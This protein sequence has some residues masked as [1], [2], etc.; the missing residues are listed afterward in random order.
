METLDQLLYWRG[1]ASDYFNYRG[2]KI[3][4][5]L[6]NRKALLRAMG[7]DPDDKAAVANAAYAL[8][9]APWTEWV[10]PFQVIEKHNQC[11]FFVNVSPAELEQEFSFEVVLEDG[12]I[13]RGKFTPSKQPEVGDYA[14]DGVRYSRRVV[15]C[16]ALPLG[17]H[18]LSVLLGDQI[19]DGQLAVVPE[20]AYLPSKLAHGE[21]I[22][23]IIVQLYTLRTQRNWGIGDLS[24][25]K[26][27][28]EK[29]SASGA[30]IIGLNPLHVLCTPV[31]HHYSPYSP[32]D[33]RYIEPLYIDPEAIAEFAEEF[34]P[35]IDELESLRASNLVDYKRVYATK[36]ATFRA[37]YAEF[38]I[39]HL[40]E[41]SARAQA[42]TRYVNR[43]GDALRGYCVYQVLRDNHSGALDSTGITPS[44][45]EQEQ[46][47]F[48]AYLQWNAQLQLSAC[49]ELA[50]ELG[51]NVGLM[52]DLAVGADGSGAEVSSTGELFCRLASVGAP[53]DPLA[54]KGQNW[55]LPP[56][57][58]AQL[59]KTRFRHYITLLRENMMSCGALR[60]DHAMALMRL[61]W[62]PPGHTADFGAYIYYPFPEMLGLLKLESVRNRCMV[63]GE[64]MGVVPD[65]F[66]EAIGKAAIF[67][68]KLFYFEREANGNFRAPDKYLPHSLAMLTNHDVP[69]L[70]SWWATTDIALRDELELLDGAVPVQQVY[71]DRNMDKYRLLEWLE[72]SGF[73]L[74][75]NKKDLVDQPLSKTLAAQ[76]FICAARVASQIF[77]IQLDDL[78]LLD[79]PVN[80]PGT[81]TQYANWQRKLEH[82]LD[83]AFADPNTISVLAEISIQRKQ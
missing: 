61:W 38:Q 72:F 10:Q 34:G 8:D 78:E 46:V 1:I 58:P 14:F 68:N 54:E 51:M 83:D 42:F 50:S 7:I 52:R 55:G 36:F 25:L 45:V 47:E 11:C 62:C 30:D 57:D 60:I 75:G 64:D 31:E 19:S 3:Q 21:K 82:D 70:A 81:S 39:L 18:G 53:P 41:N 69:T 4:V 24:D 40:R 33:R 37:L 66:R 9:V 16:G 59:R 71:N 77:V 65:E 15:M 27:L 73:T 63:V 26:S 43:E 20:K 28:I 44:S 67:A 76:I 29:S 80:V 6:E 32:S 13:Q 2:E 74:P 5:S 48:Y 56:M 35:G 49:Q 22:W 12:I 17:Y 23:G 79:A